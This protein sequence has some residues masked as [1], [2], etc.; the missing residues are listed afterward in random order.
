MKVDSLNIFYFFL[1]ESSRDNLYIS[2]TITN[3]K[4][5]TSN[6]VSAITVMFVKLLMIDGV[7]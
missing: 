6:K 7:I 4:K 2:L 3:I 1:F 5:P